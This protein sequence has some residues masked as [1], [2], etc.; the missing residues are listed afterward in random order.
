ML[1]SSPKCRL[2]YP[3]QRLHARLLHDANLSSWK[4]YHVLCVSARLGCAY[5]MKL[6]S[7]RS[8]HCPISGCRA[9]RNA[10]VYSVVSDGLF[11]DW[12]PLL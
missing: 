11:D 12:C 6:A 7:D 9:I 3:R 2:V 5:V 8:E 1:V 10:T 4:V